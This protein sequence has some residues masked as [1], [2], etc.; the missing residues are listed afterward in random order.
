MGSIR[1]PFGGIGTGPDTATQSVMVK[2][3][4]VYFDFDRRFGP[5]ITDKRGEPL[6]RQPGERD[7]FWPPFNIWLAKWLTANPE[8]KPAPHP[9][10][11]WD[12]KPNHQEER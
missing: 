10:A 3:K 7:P 11:K 6:K 1:L 5:L 9:S 12:T 2:G 4:P 8:P